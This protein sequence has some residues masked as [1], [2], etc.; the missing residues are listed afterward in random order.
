MTSPS[1][2]DDEDDELEDGL[3]TMS[4]STT[5]YSGFG[6]YL[7]GSSNPPSRSPSPEPAF[8]REANAAA[9][10]W[11]SD[12]PSELRPELPPQLGMLS[13]NNPMRKSASYDTVVARKSRTFAPSSYERQDRQERERSSTMSRRVAMSG[14]KRREME[15]LRKRLIGKGDQ[16]K[17]WAK[18]NFRSESPTLLDPVQ[19]RRS[20]SNE[21]AASHNRF[22]SLMTGTHPHIK[23]MASTPPMTSDLR[24][25]EKGET[26]LAEK[27]V[28]KVPG[29]EAH[30]TFPSTSSAP[31][32]TPATQQPIQSDSP[33]VDKHSY[34]DPAPRKKIS[35][36]DMK[37]S[38]QESVQ[39]VNDSKHVVSTQEKKKVSQQKSSTL[40]EKALKEKGIAQRKRATSLENAK[41]KE[42]KANLKKK[43]KVSLTSESSQDSK[44]ISAESLGKNVSAESASRSISASAVLSSA[45]LEASKKPLQSEVSSSMEENATSTPHLQEI[46]KISSIT[47]DEGTKEQVE[48]ED[49]PSTMNHNWQRRRRVARRAEHRRAIYKRDEMDDSD[50]VAP[51]SRTH[52]GAV[53]EGKRHSGQQEPDENRGPV[54]QD[55][56]YSGHR[57]LEDE[58]DVVP[59]GRSRSGA[60]SETSSRS[61]TLTTQDDDQPVSHGRTRSGALS[62]DS[63]LKRSS[64]VKGSARPRYQRVHHVQQNSGDDVVSYQR[65]RADDTEGATE[66][67]DRMHRRE[68][69]AGTDLFVSA[70][71]EAEAN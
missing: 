37:P 70:E 62:R 48:P 25:L 29:T 1:R 40:D 61:S 46:G 19:M 50:E 36:P 55:Q 13:Q 42:Y 49:T 60:V 52:S 66:P 41:A 5:G 18:E 12:Y 30:S 65:V 8:L 3:S 20:K 15:G 22:A 43:Q 31:L 26:Q 7:P 51:R 11:R 69:L 34:S 16:R 21:L 23:V 58:E 45:P 53:S 32:D 71:G 14:E 27:T 28:Q 35:S 47:S 56:S 67:S 38:G 6:S 64:N 54:P 68:G 44:D 59:R 2:L 63:H 57:E 4:G 10:A 33:M 17:S 24:G 9:A 39:E